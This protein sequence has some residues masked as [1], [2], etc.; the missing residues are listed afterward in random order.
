MSIFVDDAARQRM[1]A[2]VDRFTARIPRP[3]ELRRVASRLGDSHV[4]VGGSPGAPPVVLL[5]GAMASSSHVLCEGWPL[6]DRFRVYAV[7]VA[8]QSPLAPEVRPPLAGP[9]YA[10]WLGDVM[11]GLELPR[12]HVFGVSWGGFVAQNL[13]VH[14]PARIDR[15]ALVVPAGLARGSL[16]KGIT[17]AAL[18]LWRYRRAPDE[19]RLK[20]FLAAQM[21]TW[22]DDWAR[23]I[24]DALLSFR[25]DLRAP[26]LYAPAQ[27]AGFDRPTFVLAAEHDLSFDGARSVARARQLFSGLVEAE[28]LPGTKHFPPA[29]DAFRQELAARVGSFLAA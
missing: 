4:R 10:E 27:L 21:T 9:A 24:G 7:D 19:S 26:P 29:T 22:D 3:T 12:A 1:L 23:Y 2:W 13:A 16:W 17:Q 25:M 18:P 15:L 6:L 28:V 20:E 5:H 14:A 11:D 8:G